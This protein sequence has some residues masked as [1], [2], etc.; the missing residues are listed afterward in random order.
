MCIRMDLKEQRN[1]FLVTF[2]VRCLPTGNYTSSWKTG[3]QPSDMSELLNCCRWSFLPYFKLD[4]DGKWS[5]FIWRF[6]E[7]HHSSLS[8][9]YTLMFLISMA[10][11]PLA[12]YSVD[13]NPLVL[14]GSSG[15]VAF[16]FPVWVSFELSVAWIVRSRLH[17]GI[18][19]LTLVVG[20]KH[21]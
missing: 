21:M 4:K 1:C 2:M 20:S 10:L 6:K 19:D 13:R 9:I 16:T 15:T 18:M 5:V 11:A 8:T 3:V 12:S 7:I 14:D 17:L